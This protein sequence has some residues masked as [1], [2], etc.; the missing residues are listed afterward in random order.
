MPQTP[1]PACGRYRCPSYGCVYACNVCSCIEHCKAANNDALMSE[2]ALALTECW[3]ALDT[4]TAPTLLAHKQVRL[5]NSSHTQ[6]QTHNAPGFSGRMYGHDLS[7]ALAWAFSHRVFVP[8]QDV[9]PQ[10]LA[11]ASVAVRARACWL[12]GELV[13]AK[14]QPEYITQTAPAAI[15]LLD[16]AADRCG[17]TMAARTCTS[18]RDM[19]TQRW[20]Q[21]AAKASQLRSGILPTSM[22]RMHP[23]VYVYVSVLFYLL[24]LFA[25]CGG[26]ACGR[27]PQELCKSRPT[28]VTEQE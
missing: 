6:T 19:H 10:L 28:C 5:L 3:M 1:G 12:L 24:A 20:S 14:T 18:Q 9:W 15:A 27:T 26:A 13:L 17:R 16:A 7:I 21:H 25:A 8:S 11:H 2:A 4:H 23:C 22:F